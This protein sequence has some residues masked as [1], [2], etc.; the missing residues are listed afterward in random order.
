M[1][2]GLLATIAVWVICVLIAQPAGA[3][4]SRKVVSDGVDL[5]QISVASNK[6]I[7][8]IRISLD[9]ADVRVLTP[10]VP[11]LEGALPD[12]GDISR[13]G[14]GL[15]LEDYKRQFDAVAVISGG[16]MESN[17]PPS[18]L[19]LVKSN[20]IL[21]AAAN[22]SLL[23]NALFCS[24]KGRAAIQ[25]VTRAVDR[26][27]FRDCLQAGPILLQK[28]KPLDDVLNATSSGYGRLLSP[29]Q[30][31]SFACIDANAHVILGVSEEI[32]GQTLISALQGPVLRCVDAMRLTG[33]DTAGLFVKNELFGSDDYLFPNAIGVIPFSK[34]QR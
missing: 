3:E 1:M 16:Y 2:S 26:P 20:H 33:F 15:F 7:N 10:L 30:R 14:R 31:Q 19:G 8:F 27:D 28:G 5:N 34:Q 23:T 29:F 22:D 6:V 25:I 13:T 18:P 4:D 21:I 24:D 32:D 12:P 11:L 17:S 9:K